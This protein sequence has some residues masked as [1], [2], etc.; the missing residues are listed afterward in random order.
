MKTRHKQITLAI[1]MLLTGLVVACSKGEDKAASNLNQALATIPVDTSYVFFT[2]WALLKEYKGVPNLNS[3]DNLD[4]RT[5]FLISTSRDQAAASGYA[6]SRVRNHADYWTWDTTDLVWEVTLETDGPPTFVLQ[7]RD[8]FDLAPLLNLFKER[9]FSQTE[10]RGATIYSHELDLTAEWLRTTELAIVNTA[11]LEEEKRLILSSS[12]ENVKTIVSVHEGDVGSLA[13]YQAAQ[14][15]VERLGQVAAAVIGVGTDTC[16]GFSPNRLIEMMG[17]EIPKEQLAQLEALLEGEPQLH[18]YM[19]LG[20]GYRYE[21]ER[22]VGLFV[23]HY[24]NAD[25]AQADLEPRR[26]LAQDG[27]S[28]R[29]RQPYR[30]LAFTVQ[31]AF[32]QDNDLVLQVSPVNDMPRRLFSI[33]LARDMLFAA[34]P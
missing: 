32:V 33:I 23:L 22:L 19:A 16:L 3:E 34:C 18:P 14:A 1:L 12:I 2:D 20:V 29:A 21:G 11:V 10:H 28:L 26:Q 4:K 31:E 8:D 24:A 27:I 30:D 7:L 25:D 13:D 17:Q 9:G 15:T 6:V 5:E